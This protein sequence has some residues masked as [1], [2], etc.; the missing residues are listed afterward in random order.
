[1]PDDAGIM[2]VV[3]TD[4]ELHVGGSGRIPYSTVFQYYAK[5][6]VCVPLLLCD[7]CELSAFHL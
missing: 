7:H 3:R 2:P 5:S 6:S 1:M 4:T